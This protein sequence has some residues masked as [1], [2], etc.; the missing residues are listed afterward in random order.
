MQHLR[1]TSSEGYDNIHATLLKQIA[2]TISSELSYIT[3]T[4]F[5]I[6]CYCD[7]VKIAKI[8]LIVKK[9]S[10]T[11]LE[12]YR[13]IDIIPIFTKGF[14]KIVIQRREFSCTK[15]WLISDAQFGFLKGRPTELAV[16]NVTEKIKSNI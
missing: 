6:E 16:Q 9:D 4:L 12:N 3:N 2:S 1:N 10:E 15:N 14:E 8:A 13:A 7:G 11:K 5:H